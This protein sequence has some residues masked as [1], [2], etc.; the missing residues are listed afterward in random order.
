[1]ATI[2]WTDATPGP[3]GGWVNF[4]PMEWSGAALVDSGPRTATRATVSAAGAMSVTLAA[5][6]W[7]V[8]HIDGGPFFV[9]VTTSA[10][11]DDMEHYATVDDIRAARVTS[12]TTR[13]PAGWGKT[14]ADAL[15]GA[16][17]G[18]GL[19]R[20][21]IV[22]DSIAT[23]YFASDLIDTS[24]AGLV[25]AELQS[26]AGDGG[27][28]FIGA[29]FSTPFHASQASTSSTLRDA[30]ATNPGC[31]AVTGTWG[32][33]TGTCGPGGT[34]IRTQTAGA[35][36]TIT[37]RGRYLTVYTV[38]NAGG[39]ADWTYAVDGGTPVAVADSGASWSARATTIDAGDEGEHEVVIAYNGDGV[40][41]LYL[42]GIAARNTTGVVVDRY[43]RPGGTSATWQTDGLNH[44]S[45]SGGSARPADLIIFCCGLND[46]YANTSGDAFAQA[47][48]KTFDAWRDGG[49]LTGTVD[50]LILLPH[51][52]K[53]DTTNYLWGAYVDRLR[54]LA[55]SYGAAVVDV[56]AAA[57]NSWNRWNAAG[58][59]GSTTTP[60]G[61]GTD[62][63]HLSDA[64]N[65]AIADLII[66]TII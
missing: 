27:S 25:S 36:A 19:A 54:G 9:Q 53:F 39:N 41:Y 11:L 55:E 46:A 7:R 62:N 1:M 48:R 38:P 10:D 21:A 49:S 8:S 59:W 28:G 3:A 23:G 29:A 32:V 42:T 31:W 40:K 4:T 65:R 37:V 22:G 17:A 5:G 58:M 6:I 13:I 50:I 14:W 15:A 56:W 47:V 64:G 52:G 26:D 2:T 30:W 51:V 61:A 45:N 24:W 43:V 44:A 33:A 12:T 66:P 20:L 57:R 35:T 34:A 60:G 63:A 18:T 16:R